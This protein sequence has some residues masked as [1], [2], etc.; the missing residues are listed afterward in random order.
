[1]GD[2]VYHAMTEAAG[3][4]AGDRFVVIDEHDERGLLYDPSYL[5]VSRSDSVIFIQITFSTGRSL[6]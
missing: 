6:P 1:V 4:P 5:G 3:V 2:A